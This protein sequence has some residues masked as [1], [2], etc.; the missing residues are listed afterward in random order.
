MSSKKRQTNPSFAEV[1][2]GGQGHRTH[3]MSENFPIKL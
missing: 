3:L 1:K 2:S